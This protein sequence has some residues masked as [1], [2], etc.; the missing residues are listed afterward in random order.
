MKAMGGRAM[1]PG[2]IREMGANSASFTFKGF[3]EEGGV[4]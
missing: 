1:V 4:I 3:C 2:G